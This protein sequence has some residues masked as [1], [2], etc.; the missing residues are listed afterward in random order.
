[1]L[2]EIHHRLVRYLV[3]VLILGLG[4]VFFFLSSHD[5]SLQ[6]KIVTIVLVAYLLWGVVHHHLDKD[7]T[8][9]I[10][11]EYL[12]VAAVTF[13]IIFSLLRFA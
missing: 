9:L 1:M 13:V 2:E 10:F 4:L 6:L 12:L 3:L 5:P 11:L 7:L 8:G